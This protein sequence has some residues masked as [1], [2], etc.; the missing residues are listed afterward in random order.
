MNGAAVPNETARSAAGEKIHVFV[1]AVWIDTA[2]KQVTKSHPGAFKLSDRGENGRLK[3][4]KRKRW[5][6][7]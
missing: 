3:P 5:F 4:P 1:W 7:E 6:H 2:S